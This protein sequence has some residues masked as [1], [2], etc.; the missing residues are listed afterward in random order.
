MHPDFAYKEKRKELITKLL[1]EDF[2]PDSRVWIYQS[3]RPF[4]EQEEW[5][6]NE[7]LCQFTAQ[8]QS[9]GAAVKGWG[10]LLFTQFVV[11]MADEVATSVSGCATDSSVR[12]IK[13]FER[14]YQVSF[15]DR[16]LL[17]FLIKDKIQLL[18]LSQL[19]YAL[20]KG[21]IE[22]DTPFFNN[23]VGTKA[24]ME[25][26]WILPLKDSWLNSKIQAISVN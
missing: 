10:K 20:E 17:A 12:I 4:N 2:S 19:K 21:F 14:Q 9:H 8:W 13:S 26:N 7:Q 16:L 15:F 3:S 1:P 5:E 24:A 22:K 23:T 6:I 11:L 25:L 18:P